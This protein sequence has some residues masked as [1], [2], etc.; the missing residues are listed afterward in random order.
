MCQ[1]SKKWGP[2]GPAGSVSEGGAVKSASGYT[3]E[4]MPLLTDIFTESV[5]PS[6]RTFP[7]AVPGMQG[8]G[9]TRPTAPKSP[10]VGS[11][12]FGRAGV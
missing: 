7:T 2:S 3:S 12:S 1:R 9:S 11:L 6:E 4:A 10:G 8:V 5:G